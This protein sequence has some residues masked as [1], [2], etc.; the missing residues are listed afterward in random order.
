MNPINLHIDWKAKTVVILRA[1]GNIQLDIDEAGNTEITE[2]IFKIVDTKAIDV[3]EGIIAELLG[4]D[5]DRIAV[6]YASWGSDSSIIIGSTASVLDIDNRLAKQLIVLGVR[7]GILYQSS[8]YVWKIKDEVIQSRWLSKAKGIQEGPKREPETQQEEF[9]R[10]RKQGFGITK[11]KDEGE[12]GMIVEGN[13]IEDHVEVIPEKPLPKIDIEAMEQELKDFKEMYEQLDSGA[14]AET[15]K[16]NKN[17]LIDK[18]KPLENKI[19]NAKIQQSTKQYSGGV[20]TKPGGSA[21]NI[22]QVRQQAKEVG[23]KQA[24]HEVLKTQPKQPLVPVKKVLPSVK[25]AQDK[26]VRKK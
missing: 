3:Y 4:Y 6:L 23:K 21:T 9:A 11:G 13:M 2:E 1:K 17:I 7:H 15:E 12:E 18:I 5:E 25:P 8:S 16:Y 24:I 22:T 26:P 10:L 14:L 19:K 20:P